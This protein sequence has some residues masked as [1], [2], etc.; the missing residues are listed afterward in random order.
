MNRLEL[1]TETLRAALNALAA[2]RPRLAALGRPRRMVHALQ[3]PR[4]GHAPASRGDRRARSTRETVGGDG[5]ALRL[6]GWRTQGSVPTCGRLAAVADTAPGLGQAL[7]P[8][9]GR[10][11]PSG[12]RTPTWPAPPAPSSPPMIPRPATATSATL[13]WTGYK[14]HLTETCDPDLPRLITDVHTTVA[15]TQD[16][17]CTADIQQSLADRG[18]LPE[19]HLVD[20]GYVDAQ[21][22]VESQRRHGVELFGPTRLNP[23]WQAREGGYDQSR[24]SIVGRNSRRPVPRAGR[25]SGGRGPSR[26]AAKALRPAA[27][28]LR[29]ASRSATAPACASRA[30]CVR[31]PRGS[32]GRTGAAGAG[33]L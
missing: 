3:P 11:G 32:P 9:R 24:F 6:E 25:P 17:S 28:S 31:S 8:L 30:K 33:A 29:C 13:S 27:T 18:L 1:V 16:V 5:V 19:R 15:T 4:G 2:S 7:H 12:G 14:V 22:L 26:R 10:R 23:S 20:T 21:L